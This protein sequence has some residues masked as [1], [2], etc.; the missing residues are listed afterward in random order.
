[1][2]PLF[3][4]L[5]NMS[6]VAGIMVLIILILRLILKKAPKKFVCL[7]WALVALRLIFPFSIS[8]DFSVFNLLDLGTGEK[9]QVE[10]F[11]FN[12]KSEK[13]QL[14]FELPALV[15]DNY[16]S[17]SVTFGT[18]TSGVYLPPLTYIWIAG[19]GCML[20]YAGFCYLQLRRQT[21]A[22]IESGDNIYVCDDIDSPFILGI[23]CPRIYLP[24]GMSDATRRTVISHE[25]AHIKRHDHWWKPLGYLL[26]SVY[27]FNPLLW[28][29]YVLL[30]RD[31]EAACDERVVD[32][33]DK[34][35]VSEYSEALLACAVSRR[36]IT[37]CPLAFGETNVKGRVKNV[38][39]YKKP[40]FWIICL[41]VI[42]CAA[43]ALCLLTD[44]ADAENAQQ[45]DPA[46]PSEDVTVGADEEIGNEAV[47]DPSEVKMIAVLTEIG[48]GTMTV[49]PVEGSWELNS[50]DTFAVPIEH[51][52][53]SPEPMVGD[54]LEITYSGDILETYPAGLGGVTRIHVIERIEDHQ[55]IRYTQNPDGTYTT[56]DGE[57]YKYLL[58]LIGREA[59]ADSDVFFV[60][61]TD[62]PELSFET[63]NSAFTTAPV[64]IAGRRE[65]VT[66]SV[67]LLEKPASDSEVPEPAE[68]EGASVFGNYTEN[69]DGTYTAG[70]GRTYKYLLKLVG[71]S[72]N[73]ACDSY[74]LVLSNNADLQFERVNEAMIT[75]STE[76]FLDPEEA[77]MVGLG[78]IADTPWAWPC[79]SN[80]VSSPFGERIQPVSDSTLFHDEVDIAAEKGA[81]VVSAFTGSVI[82]AG[83][84]SAR[85]N[86]VEILHIDDANHE[87]EIITHYAH[88]DEICVNV[89]DAV[90]GGEKVGT[91]GST[92]HSTGPHLAFG[93]KLNGE[94]VDPMDFFENAE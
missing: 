91:V 19:A 46:G 75:S 88:L 2:Y 57:T 15:N 81:P 79:E 90:L 44:P 80:K 31:I 61:L 83:Y 34:S 5:M 48:D 3:T 47:T 58:N 69:A 18:R 6:L 40:A 21:G 26:L 43:A 76:R 78:V 20:V 74:Y 7:L 87:G 52:E 62:N 63:V 92:G 45:H 53:A 25:R 49:V 16:S 68:N 37:A 32:G 24:S 23:V 60:V 8:S 64:V 65:F 29:A 33:L 27:W 42:L 73:A 66:V 28:L 59:G 70:N 41:A 11:E 72:L 51:M 1:M 30:C 38:L 10:Y 55:L 84:E 35:G 89:G 56:E 54:T 14:N 22:S 4:R 82:A 13:P 77:V 67:E 39:N 36:M 17:D 94:Y 9:G 93:V 50:S 86:Y 71:R 85:G 12:G